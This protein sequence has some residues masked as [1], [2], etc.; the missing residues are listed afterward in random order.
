MP[1]VREL[2]VEPPVILKPTMRIGEVLPKMKE[3]RI[4]VAPVVNDDN[5]LIGVLSY[6]N[7][8][9]RG[10]GRDTKVQ[11]VME[12]P[13]SLNENVDF[14][15]AVMAF[16]N[17]RAREI[18]VTNANEVVVGVV[19]R[20]IILDYMLRN[21]L[22][23]SATVDSAMSKPA[24]TIEESESIARARWLML[25]SGI[26]RLVVVDKTGRVAGVITLSDIVERLYTIRLSKR[27]GYEWI[28]SEESFLAAPVADYMT[29]PPITIPSGSSLVKAI[30]ILLENR[31][32]GAPVV[33]ADDKPLGVFSGLD[34]LKLYLDQLKISMPI[35]A[36]IS[37][38]VKEDFTR[39]QIEKLVNSYLSKFSRY[40]NV[41]D[42][43]LAV[44]EE[45]KTD[46]EGRR[47][48][49]VRVRVVTDSGALTSQSVCWDLSTCVREALEI[50]EKRL[51]KQVE[52]AVTA[53][54]KKKREGD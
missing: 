50:I 23:P 32:S 30:N 31:I 54:R 17:W 15:R 21:G 7:I 53:K 43:K 40:V 28:Q 29:S 33:T 47:R 48:Y 27:K 24:I 9:M 18:P 36:K 25:K 35:E 38:V 26:S 44:K 14:D 49:N 4:V 12:P 3:H 16:V 22:V 51:R 34:A 42:F 5:V 6:R 37:Q 52:K 20:N 8:L 10:V 39:L 2:S 1:I 45:T 46:K 13:Y 41:I 11:T 19:S